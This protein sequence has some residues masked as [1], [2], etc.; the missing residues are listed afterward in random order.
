[1]TDK[2]K[3]SRFCL[4]TYIVAYIGLP[5][6]AMVASI[7]LI[8]ITLGQYMTDIGLLVAMGVMS[9]P[10]AFFSAGILAKKLPQG[11]RARCL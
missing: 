3:L 4:K 2:R 9:I 10:T 7:I 1:M 11:F 8:L 6:V 5:F